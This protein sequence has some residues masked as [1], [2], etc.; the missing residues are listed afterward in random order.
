M[1][2]D[3]IYDIALVYV[4]VHFLNAAYWCG[5]NL[6]IT[7]QSVEKQADEFIRPSAAI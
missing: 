1:Y 5:I 2:C 3:E 7:N 4:E 6:L